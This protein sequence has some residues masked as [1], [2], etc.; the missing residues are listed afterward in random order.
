M[1]ATVSSPSKLQEQLVAHHRAADGEGER[2]E[3]RL[4]ADRRRKRRDMQR[5]GAFADDLD[6]IDMGLVADE[7]FERGIDLIVAAGRA[8]H[9]S[10]SA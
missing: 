8:L 5:V 9:D 6:V 1:L 2:V 10:R 4:G 3:A 7:Q